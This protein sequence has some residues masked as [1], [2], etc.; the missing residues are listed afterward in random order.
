[1]ITEKYKVMKIKQLSVFLENKTGRINDM[2]NV[3]RDANIN[4][5]A[6]SL[7]ESSEFGIMR[8]IVADSD[9]AVKVLRDNRFT[10]TVTE[11]V[12]LQIEDKPG[13]LAAVLENLTAKDIFMEYMYAF[14]Q[15]NAAYV[16]IRPTDVDGCMEVLG[17]SRCKLLSTEELNSL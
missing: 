17:Q 7:A 16:V 6:F 2:V 15:D 10:V 11:V 13:A 1:M 3:L 9:L 14:S 5:S 12:C 4:M 8:M